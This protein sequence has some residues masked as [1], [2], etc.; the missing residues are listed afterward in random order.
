MVM[1]NTDG[2]YAYLKGRANGD[3]SRSRVQELT[4]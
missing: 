3:I 4:Q 2:L 1:K